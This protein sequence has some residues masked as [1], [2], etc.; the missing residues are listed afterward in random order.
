MSQDIEFY[1]A[2]D[3]V[4]HISNAKDIY[5]TPSYGVSAELIDGGTWEC[6]LDTTDGTFF[7]YLRRDIADPNSEQYDIVS[8]Y[9]YGGICPQDSA[10][11]ANFRGKFLKASRERG[12]VA[13]FIRTNPLDYDEYAVDAINPDSVSRHTTFGVGFDVDPNEYFTDAEGRHR[14]AVRKAE[15][16]GLEVIKHPITASLDPGSAFRTLYRNTMERVGASSRLKLDT[17]YFERMC[18]VGEEH[19]FIAEVVDTE[20]A[21][22]ASSVF[23]THDIRVHYHLSGTTPEGQK[24]GA[25]NLLID[26]IVRNH[27][28]PKGILH[29]GGGV[30]A[31]DGLEKF[32]RSISNR[33]LQVHLCRTVVNH[34]A[35]DSL[36]RTADVNPDFDGYFPAYRTR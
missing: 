3:A 20:G 13:E 6:A 30:S 32:K 14:T 35:Y 22:V 11:I 18:G 33:N 23:L 19:G 17:N 34:E 21:V 2:A 16:S 1:D 5:Y 15:K 12:L 7:P 8:P 10:D 31:N 4:K 25:T 27:L 9:G 29:L 24:L 36:C 28:Q 26:W